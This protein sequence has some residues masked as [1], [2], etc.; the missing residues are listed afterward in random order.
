L[1]TPIGEFCDHLAPA[2]HKA[3]LRAYG[4]VDPVRWVG[5]GESTPLLFQNGRR[6]PIS[7]PADV[8]ALV[9]AAKKP[10]TLRWYPGGHE[11]NEQARSDAEEWLV[12][13]LSR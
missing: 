7:P 1:S 11:L 4:A 2:A 5:R 12:R 8:T 13:L 9:R 3:Y 6:D 10:K